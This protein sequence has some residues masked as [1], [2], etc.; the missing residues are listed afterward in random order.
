MNRSVS[1]RDRARSEESET[2][3][4]ASSDGLE[5]RE[6]EHGRRAG[7]EAADA[8]LRRVV[9]RHRERGRVP[10]PPGDRLARGGL[11]LRRDPQERGGAGP[12]VE[13]LVGAA[14]RQ[15]RARGREVDRDRAGGVAQ[16]PL[17][18]RPAR[19]GSGRDRRHVEH[20]PG[21]EV[22]V[23]QG[24]QRDVVVHRRERVGGVAPAQ[25][26]AHQLGDAGRDVPVGGEGGGLDDQH[27]A[28][29]TQPGRGH[30]GLEQAHAGAVAEVHVVGPGPDE[31]GDP[32]RD[33]VAQLHPARVVPGAD[34]AL[35]PL[36]DHDVVQ[37]VGHPGRRRAERVAV[38]VDQ[39]G[40]QLEAAHDSSK[41]RS[42]ARLISAWKVSSSTSLVPAGVKFTWAT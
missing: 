31:R 32:G 21:P 4:K 14:H 29:G 8:F 6:G 26:E 16:V 34:Q 42:R 5:R 37:P 24:E 23:R 15:V 18:Q 9:A 38:E 2:P 10:H 27:P 1:S 39:P 35:A 13:V 19:L 33:P 22:D 20:R 7:R 30:E 36:P 41:R 17:H 12:A 3:S 28:L 25:L 11:V 40:G